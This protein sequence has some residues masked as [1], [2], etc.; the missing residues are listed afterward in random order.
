MNHSR[1]LEGVRVLDLTRLVPGA[2]CTALLAD[3]GADVLK[4]E[5]PGRGDSLRWMPPRVK[6]YSAQFLTLNRNKR[7]MTLD[8]KSARG[9]EIFLKLV[10]RAAVVLAG[11][12]PGV[13]ER[14]HLAYPVLSRI[15]PSLIH[16]SITGFGQSGPYRDRPAHDINYIAIAGILG[17]TG[18]AGGPPAIPGMQIADIAAG[19]LM[20]TVA[21]LIALLARQRTGRGQFIDVAMLDGAFSCLAMYVSKYLGDGVPIQRGQG[22]TN[23]GSP[24]INVYKT[25]DDRY[26]S[27][28]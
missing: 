18:T 5:E 10:R 9:R 15:N 26:L 2:Y 17:L 3:F 6:E 7:S 19:G 21:I 25:T 13:M 20:A 12:R 27:G 22:R 14:L 1:A 28:H 11:F 4:V 8:L 16:C 24:A 23:G